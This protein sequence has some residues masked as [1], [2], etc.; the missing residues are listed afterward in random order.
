MASDAGPANRGFAPGDDSVLI[1][2][3]NHHWQLV[4]VATLN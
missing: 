1:E 4:F 3:M 2:R